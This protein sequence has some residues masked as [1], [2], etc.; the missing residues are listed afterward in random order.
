MNTLKVGDTKCT[1]DQ[2]PKNRLEA[3]SLG[4]KKYF[5]DKPC[6]RGHISYRYVASGLC[7]ECASVKAKKNW[8]DGV[9]Q[10]FRDRAATIKKWNDS[11]KAK[12]AKEKWKGRNP[13]RAWA[14]YATGA[15]KVRAALKGVDFDITSGYVESIT[16]DVCPI[17]KESFLFVGNKTMRPFSASLDRLDPNRG[18]VKGNVV[19]ISVKANS[20]KNA[21]GSKDIAAVATWLQQQGH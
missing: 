12:Q 14:V 10:T 4:F 7:A 13:K 20:I 2:L 3:H 15:A 8:A 21:Y 1:I 5:T 17:F 6:L 9:R 16:P 11:N 18:Y 19:V